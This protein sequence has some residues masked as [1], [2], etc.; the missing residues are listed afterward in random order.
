MF[1]KYKKNLNVANENKIK[2]ET[3]MPSKQGLHGKTD[4]QKG[5]RTNS[6]GI[7]KGTKK[8]DSLR[9]HDNIHRQC[10]SRSVRVWRP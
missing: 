10:G 7:I 1:E 9:K 3:I 8:R 5:K 6:K 4:P 2:R